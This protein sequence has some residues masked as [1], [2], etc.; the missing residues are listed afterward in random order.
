MD[1]SL[2]ED[3]IRPLGEEY[4]AAIN[5]SGARIPLA[6]ETRFKRHYIIEKPGG[7]SHFDVSRFLDGGASIT[8]DQLKNEWTTWPDA[9]RADFCASMNELELI[10]QKDYAQIVRF[11]LEHATCDILGGVV[12]RLPVRHT[13]SP[14]ETFDLLV[15]VLQRATPGHAAD[16]VRALAL[17]QHA[18]A[19]AMIRERLALVAADPATW[20]DANHYNGLASDAA[21]C[22]V[23][24]FKLGVPTVE[25][26]DVVRQLCAHKCRRSREWCRRNFAKHYVWLKDCA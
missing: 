2:Y 6:Y 18:N 1:H 10:G 26:E 25:L 24:L 23:N 13:F 14:D 21:Y 17:T 16:V 9:D 11:L 3:W 22:I 5:L 4:P 7:V 12:L 15:R 20:D 19:E 8:L